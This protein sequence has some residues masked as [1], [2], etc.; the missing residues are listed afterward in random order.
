MK[1]TE[2]PEQFEVTVTPE[3]LEQAIKDVTNP[4]G[5]TNYDNYARSC[6]IAQAVA[7]LFPN[8][9]VSVGANGTVSVIRDDKLVGF[10]RDGREARDLVERFDG[11]GLYRWKPKSEAK[12]VLPLTLKFEFDYNQLDDEDNI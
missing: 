11:R 8:D 9:Q 7:P 3:H 5:K 1:P 4:D 6:V 12:E 10:Y 2:L